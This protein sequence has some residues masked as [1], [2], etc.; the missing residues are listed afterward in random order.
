[1]KIILAIFFLFFFNLKSS[2]TE[3]KI[4]D[5]SP[6]YWEKSTWIPAPADQIKAHKDLV[7]EKPV[8]YNND[9]RWVNQIFL[10][11]DKPGPFPVI[12]IMPDCGSV[13]PHNLDFMQKAFQRGY[14][15]IV[16]DTHRGFR[17]N[18][19]S[20]REK[21]V[22]W[23]RLTKD[24]YDIAAFLSTLPNI[25]KNRIY[26]I[27]GSEGGMVGGFLTS[28]GVKKFTA[29]DAPRYRANASFYGCAVFPPGSFAPNQTKSHMYIFNDMDKP[30]LWLMGEADNECVI[31][32]EL[33]IISEFQK[34]KLPIE[35]HL[36]K[37]V[38]HCW[39]CKA[40]DG[41]KQTMSR[42]GSPVTVVYKYDQK[43]VDDSTDRVI[44]FFD[45]YK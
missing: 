44:N 1:M 24:A 28:P 37:D 45:K 27:G 4:E 3:V 26:S 21:P 30:L 8:I 40:K 7:F 32:S 25:N 5:M 38:T 31:K 15:A 41:L 36:Y 10:P 35:Y 42:F 29:P 16:L 19:G 34:K 22:N 20:S 14:A 39:D 12:V 18:C 11:N 17:I 9:A 6:S 33:Q 23:L 43:I 2:A 13:G